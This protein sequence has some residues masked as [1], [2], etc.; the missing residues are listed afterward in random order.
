MAEQPSKK[1]DKVIFI[2][3]RYYLAI[4]DLLLFYV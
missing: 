1:K 3:I 2:V 4:P